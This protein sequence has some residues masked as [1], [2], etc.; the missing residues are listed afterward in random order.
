M[1]SIRESIR[2]NISLMEDEHKPELSLYKAINKYF[3]EFGPERGMMVL[4]RILKEIAKKHGPSQMTDKSFAPVPIGGVT[5][6][7]MMDE[8]E[9]IDDI[10]D[11]L[12]Q[13]EKF[14]EILNTTYAS[15]FSDEF[16]YADNII[17]Y[18]I[19]DYAGTAIEE[20]LID[21]IKD[22]YGEQLLDLY[23]SDEDDDKD[24]DNDLEYFV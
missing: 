10:G 18:L 2:K 4:D 15:D 23:R 14:E 16:E 11:S 3:K 7:E 24:G 12:I 9:S 1:K 22:V 19:S 5:I 21:Y 8:D 6:H 20:D 13:S 17:S